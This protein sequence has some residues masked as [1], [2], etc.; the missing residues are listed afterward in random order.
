MKMANTKGYAGFLVAFQKGN[1]GRQ[2]LEFT[3]G[4]AGTAEGMARSYAQKYGSA[5]LIGY[6]V[7]K[8][9]RTGQKHRGAEVVATFSKSAKVAKVA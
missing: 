5:V 7:N 1:E 4:E 6:K 8:F 3:P 2:E 9:G